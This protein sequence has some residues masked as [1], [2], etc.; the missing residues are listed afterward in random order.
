[1]MPLV[2]SAGLYAGSAILLRLAGFLVFLWLARALAVADYAGW[3]LLYALQTGIATFGL[4]GVIEAVVGLLKERSSADA[5]QS[6]FSAANMAFLIVGAVTVI[7]AMFFFWGVARSHTPFLTVA[8]AIGSGML[9]AYASLQ[10]QIVRL[11]EKHIASLCFNFVVPL[12]GF[13][14][15]AIAFY[16]MRSV[17]AYFAGLAVGAGFSLAGALVIGMG[18]L[19]STSYHRDLY[20]ILSRVHP[21]IF[22]GLIG[23][24]SGYGTNYLINV[25]FAPL[26]VAR[27]TFVFSLSAVMQLIATS[28]NQVWSPRFYQMIHEAPVADIERRNRLFFQIEALALGFVGAG[29]LVVYPFAIRLLGGNASH[30][31]DM[32]P[33]LFLLILGYVVTVPTWHAQNYLLAFDKGALIR[34]VHIVTGIVGAIVGIFLMWKIGPMGIY[35]SFLI[36]MLLRS[37]GMFIAARRN[38]PVRLA[39]Q[40][41]G[42]GMLV[43]LVGLFGSGVFA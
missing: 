35:I 6:L 36:Q 17:A 10:A 28:M 26:Q 1:M 43:A 19:P 39:W 12:A 40:G 9:L 7:L 23:W 3:G 18:F 21:F 24:L 22:V 8:L 5:R 13:L 4:T 20:P 16:F 27:F 14:G 37:T 42:I 33:E 34:D 25:F 30:Y 11:E 2:F 41:I 32:R 31:A 29:M 15:S 38:W